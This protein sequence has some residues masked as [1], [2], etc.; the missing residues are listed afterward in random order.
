[1]DAVQDLVGIDAQE[2]DLKGL[3]DQGKLMEARRL[4][5]GEDFKTA[6]L[7]YLDLLKSQNLET[8]RKAKQGLGY[9]MIE[10]GDITESEETTIRTRGYVSHVTED[11]SEK[12]DRVL[13]DLRFYS[14]RDVSQVHISRDDLDR[15]LSLGWDVV[16]DTFVDGIKKKKRMMEE[17]G[18][19][20]AQLRF[21]LSGYPRALATLN[22]AFAKTRNWHYE[23]AIDLYRELIE[24]RNDSKPDEV[25]KTE[26]VKNQAKQTLVWLLMHWYEYNAVQPEVDKLVGQL[27]K[28]GKEI[29]IGSIPKANQSQ[30]DAVRDRYLMLK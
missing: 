23:E 18:K 12:V 10:L 29:D 20:L 26:N 17:G 11:D 24:A 7:V 6:Y 2:V 21:E 5:D 3:D 15:V 19:L 13:A 30:Q 28:A 4:R 1:M 14:G 9:C 25:E 27:K 16:D 22:A 8:V